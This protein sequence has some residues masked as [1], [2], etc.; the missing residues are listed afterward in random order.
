MVR[1]IPRDEKARRL[2]A[3]Q[4]TRWL[5]TAIPFYSLTMPDADVA[6]SLKVTIEEVQEA[7]AVDAEKRARAVA[8]SARWNAKVKFSDEEI[9]ESRMTGTRNQIVWALSIRRKSGAPADVLARELTASFWINGRSNFPWTGI[10]SL[11]SADVRRAGFLSSSAA[12]G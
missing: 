8:T 9:V 5:K 3:R 12:R 2:A 7:K 1:R 6:A 10:Q 11:M 4:R